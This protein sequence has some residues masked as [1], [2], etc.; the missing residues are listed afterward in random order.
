MKRLLPI[1]I[2]MILV[3]A[4]EPAESKIDFIDTK[5]KIINNKLRY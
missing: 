4:Q 5:D 3:S 2:L 1:F